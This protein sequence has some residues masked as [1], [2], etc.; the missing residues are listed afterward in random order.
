KISPVFLGI[1]TYRCR[2]YVYFTRHSKIF[3]ISNFCDP[4]LL[5]AGVIEIV[6]SI[7]LILGLCTRQAAFILSG[8][9][10]YAYFFLHV[11]G[12]GNLFFPIANGGELALLY[13]L[14]FL[15]FVF[16]GAGACAL[17]NKFFKK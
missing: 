9:M 6:G 17:D 13:S 10:A 12:K 4:M 3:G 14:L 1:F 5:V 16:S 2:L 8:E 11:A 7:L 15:Y